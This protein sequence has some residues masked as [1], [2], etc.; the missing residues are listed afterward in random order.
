MYQMNIPLFA[1]I[2]SL[3]SAPVVIN[4]VGPK[5]FLRFIIT[6]NPLLQYGSTMIRFIIVR[7]PGS[8]VLC[9]A[10]Y[11]VSARVNTECV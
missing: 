6:C 8:N 2:F 9:D 11:D 3:G 4:I 5:A 1:L 7:F 10:T